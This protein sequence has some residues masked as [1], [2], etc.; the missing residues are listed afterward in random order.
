MA[1]EKQ[2]FVYLKMEGVDTTPV[3]VR[4][5]GMCVSFRTKDD[6]DEYLH[7]IHNQ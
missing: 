2:V 3:N 6:H 1:R 4:H 7:Q 5:L